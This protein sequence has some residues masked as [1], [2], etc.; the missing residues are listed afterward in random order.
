MRLA[1]GKDLSV[2]LIGEQGNRWRL[3]TR[4]DGMWLAAGNSRWMMRLA[5][6]K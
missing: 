2:A 4:G 1:M 3:G 6:R 5:A